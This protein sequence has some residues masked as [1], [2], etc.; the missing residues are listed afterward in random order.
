MIRFKNYPYQK[1]GVLLGRVKHISLSTDDHSNYYVETSLPGVFKTTHHKRIVFKREMQG[2]AE[3]I[4]YD[5]RL[6]ERIFYSFDLYFD[7]IN[8]ILNKTCP[9]VL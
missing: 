9:P 8:K 1:F 6:I 4:I 2:T 5:I 7:T 3:I